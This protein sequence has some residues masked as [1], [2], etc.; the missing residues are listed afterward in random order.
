MYQSRVHLGP[1]PGL[2]HDLQNTTPTHMTTPIASASLTPNKSDRYEID[3]IS[4]TPRPFVFY[5][6]ASEWLNMQKTSCTILPERHLLVWVLKTL[7]VH[8]VALAKVF[9][10]YPTPISPRRHHIHPRLHS[11]CTYKDVISFKLLATVIFTL[12]SGSLSS[13]FCHKGAV[14][15]LGPCQAL[16]IPIQAGYNEDDASSGTNNE[17]SERSRHQLHA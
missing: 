11:A 2:S 5:K 13:K 9:R 1:S 8:S 15:G 3:G 7:T 10:S 12:Y 17:W 4:C 14:V 6:L 16:H